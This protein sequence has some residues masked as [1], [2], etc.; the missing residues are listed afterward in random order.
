MVEVVSENTKSNVAFV[1]S[2]CGRQSREGLGVC[3]Q[4]RHEEKGSRIIHDQR[5]KITVCTVV[6]M[7]MARR[8]NRAV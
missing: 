4:D 5:L 8:R 7:V 3:Q 2:Q 6:V 1:E